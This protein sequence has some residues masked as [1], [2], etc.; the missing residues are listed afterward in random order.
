MT[1]RVRREERDVVPEVEVAAARVAAPA[2]NVTADIVDRA[3]EEVFAEAQVSPEVAQVM[4]NLMSA[5][6][7]S[8]VAHAY[9]HGVASGFGVAP[10]S[11]L[12]KPR[13]EVP[14]ALSDAQVAALSSYAADF[15]LRFSAREM[16]DHPVAAACRMVDRAIINSRV[17]PGAAVSDVGG[18][19]VHLV[20]SGAFTRGVHSCAPSIDPKD[21]V[22]HVLARLQLRKIA[23]DSKRETDVRLAAQRV[24]AA[25]PALVCNRRVQDCDFATPV[26]TSVHVYDVPMGDWPAIMQRKKAQLVEGCLLFPRDIFRLQSS[27]MPVAGARYEVDTV[28]DVFRMGFV[29]SPSWWYSHKLSEYLKYG[30]DQVLYSEK[31]VYSYKVVERRGDT[32]F[33]RILRVGANTLPEY[34]QTYRLPGVPMVR[35]DGFP[36]HRVN[37]SLWGNARRTYLFPEPLWNDMLG[38]AKEMVERD[39]LTPE[40]LFNYY[41]TVA[42]RQSINAVVVAGGSTVANLNELVP[43][44]VHVVLFAFME[45]RKTRIESTVLVESELL[46]RRRRDEWTLYK[47]LAGF[48]ASLLGLTSLTCAPLLWVSKMIGVGMDKFVSGRAYEWRVEA[49]VQEVSA[50]LVLAASYSADA[51][52]TAD[53]FGMEE[54]ALAAPL[55][56]VRA[57]EADGN[58][59]QMLLDGFSSVLAP[60]QV[61]SLRKALPDVEVPVKLAEASSARTPT[62]EEVSVSNP[63]TVA[64]MEVDDLERLRRKASILEAIDECEAEAA[65]SEAACADQFRELMIGGAPNRRKLDSRREMFGNPEFWHVTSGVVDG[66]F[67]GAPVEGFVHAAVFCPVPFEGERLL[68]VVEEEFKGMSKGEYVERLWYKLPNLGY[69]GWVYTNDSLLIHNGPAIAQSMRDS[70][71]L[72]M[73]FTVILNQGPPGCGK[74]TQ[75]I[76]KAKP[77]DVILVPV[78]KS[79]RETADRLKKKSPELA[80]MFPLRVRTL[81]SYLV[82]VDRNKKLRNLSAVRL[83]AD[84]GFMAREGRWLAAAARL[85]VS[86]IEAFGDKEQIP[87]VPR[88]EC[89]K[90]YVSLRYQLVYESFVSYRCPPE[91]V[92]CWGH[93]YDWKVRSASRTKGIVSQVSN[94]VGVN[95]PSGCVMMGMYQADKKLL[96]EKYS[97]C[98]SSV[99]IMTVHESQGNTYRHVWLHRFDNRRRTDTFSLYDK[100]AYVLVAMSRSTEEFKYVSPPLGDLVSR[101]IAQGQD[102]RRINAA[103]DLASAGTPMEYL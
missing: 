34:R 89:P 92:A 17:P 40:R 57:A 31:A 50:K 62:V 85:G 47:V 58:V 67:S 80:S 72:P 24:L 87:H 101:W 9:Y 5:D 102:K 32:I 33:F 10:S 83:L 35:V 59:A 1:T 56:V 23:A 19:L 88:A 14:Y 66:S 13:L 43:L 63:G 46:L 61:A 78:R 55:N 73:D 81:D 96:Q 28:R 95:I 25:D 60:S 68:T 94:T 86:V 20:T 7:S 82:N 71:N 22:R 38:H 45:V 65:K 54:M 100:P 70:L 6:S 91:L 99:H 97:S 90:N 26:L 103:A 21:P 44:I 4:R 69:T 74:T 27:E 15:S 11:V 76:D 30:V 16:H 2:Y 41:R 29:G 39:T 18:A 48:G 12:E 37:H 3:V 53:P 77:D 51:E 75:I 79:V 52:L 93:V 8:A 42:P 84:E 36:V 98:G 49:V 64:T